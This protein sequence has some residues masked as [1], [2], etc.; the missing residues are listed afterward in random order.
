VPDNPERRFFE[1][2][3]IHVLESRCLIAAPHEMP[4]GAMQIGEDYGL[5]KELVET[6]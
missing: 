5:V 2:L 3:A 6:L 4:C 1:T